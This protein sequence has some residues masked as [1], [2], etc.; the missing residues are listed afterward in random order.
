MVLLS[1][2]Y[3]PLMDIYSYS[4][5]ASTQPCSFY[6]TAQPPFYIRLGFSATNTAWSVR[7]IST[8]INWQHI[9]YIPLNFN[10]LDSPLTLGSSK[11]FVLLLSACSFQI[12]IPRLPKQPIMARTRCGSPRR[13]LL[14]KKTFK[15]PCLLSFQV[16][17]CLYPSQV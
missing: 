6:R 7:H 5:V 1:H 11:V 13:F 4:C 3:F 10:L 14:L 12:P 9:M 16:Y 15:I 2:F 8:Y 17:V